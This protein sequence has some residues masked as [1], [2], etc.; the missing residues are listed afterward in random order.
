MSENI[1]P[2]NA[3]TKNIDITLTWLRATAVSSKD[4]YRTGNG[5]ADNALLEIVDT[6]L[7]QPTPKLAA[8]ALSG[9]VRGNDYVGWRRAIEGYYKRING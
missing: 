5:I 9:T 1:V 3:H 6:C 8:Q 4:G 2:E 7:A